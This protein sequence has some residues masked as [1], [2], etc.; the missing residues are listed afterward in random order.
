MK[1]K[2]LSVLFCLML[3]F[4]MLLVACDNGEV[5]KND[6]PTDFG[7]KGGTQVLDF[8]GNTDA[9]TSDSH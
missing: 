4:G 3:V 2:I 7:T 5:P 1:G 8:S 6:T 9:L